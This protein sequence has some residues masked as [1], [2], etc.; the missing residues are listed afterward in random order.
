MMKKIALFVFGVLVFGKLFAAQAFIPYIP[1]TSTYQGNNSVINIASGTIRTLNTPGLIV[2][3]ATGTTSTSAT[4]TTS[5]YIDTNLGS[6]ITVKYATSRVKVEIYQSCDV[7]TSAANGSLK[8]LRAAATVYGPYP[9]FPSVAAFQGLTVPIVFYDLP[10]TTGNLT[11]KT[12]MALTSG[13]GSFTCQDSFS[14]VPMQSY[15]I[16]EEITQ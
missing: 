5:S 14:A 6:T 1:S 11:Y 8:V 10:G 16:L 2:T 9:F 12:Q 3:I 7:S 15:I 13:S 4:R